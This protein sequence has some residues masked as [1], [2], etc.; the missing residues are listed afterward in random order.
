MG[1]ALAF[2]HPSPSQ[3][4][5]GWYYFW[6]RSRKPRRVHSD[7]VRRLCDLNRHAIHA[8][9]MLEEYPS[10]LTGGLQAPARLRSEVVMVLMGVYV[11]FGVPIYALALGKVAG[12]CAL[13]R[14][15]G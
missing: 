11:L 6:N 1:T 9:T 15:G 4:R 7:R 2:V 5:G 13:L 14:F 8:R 12:T 3:M 10:Q